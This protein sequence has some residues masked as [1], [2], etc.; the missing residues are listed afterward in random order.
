MDIGFLRTKLIANWIIFGR[1]R[2]EAS[3][4]TKHRIGSRLLEMQLVT[5][6]CIVRAVLHKVSRQ[7]LSTL[8]AIAMVSLRLPQLII[9]DVVQ[10]EPAVKRI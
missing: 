4:Y 2:N 8:V 3:K 5:V 7:T 6:S 9:M 10:T 1:P